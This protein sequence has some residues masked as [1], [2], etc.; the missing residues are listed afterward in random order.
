MIEHIVLFKFKKGIEKEK[1]AE[2]AEN[3]KNLRSEI[4]AIKDLS[5]G[6]NFSTRNKD[7][8]VGLV[9]R[10]DSKEDLMTYQKHPKHLVV[11]EEDVRPIIEDVLA[12]D[13]EF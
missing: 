4:P 9:V 3:I 10:F 7:F 12:V 5:I 1:I 8:S 2:M 11:I 6:E 13:Y